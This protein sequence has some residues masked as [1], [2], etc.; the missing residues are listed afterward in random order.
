MIENTRTESTT[1]ETTRRGT[2]RLEDVINKVHIMSQNHHDKTIPVT[3]MEFS[4][5]DQM[6]IGSKK[7]EVLPSAQRLI[8]QRLRV[9]HSYLS[10]CDQELQAKNLNY[11]IEKE[12]QNRD[13][14]F[15]RFDGDKVRAV[16]TDS[17]IP[18]DNMQVLS[19]MLETGF[20]PEQ[21]VQYHL[22]ENLMVVKVPEYS[23]QFEVDTNDSIVPGVSIGN[24][25]VGVLAFSIQGYF[26]RLLCL[27][28]LITQTRGVANR[29]KHISNK[30]L[31]HFPEILDRVV[32]ESRQSQ[33][34][35]RF[36]L[37]SNVQDPMASISTFNK[38][39]NITNGT[40]DAV[41]RGFGRFQGHTMF[42]IINAYTAA[43]QEPG[44]TVEASHHL[45]S[46]GGK[47]LG[48]VKH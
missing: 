17:Y 28:G 46:V 48:M 37:Q 40:A 20:L 14:F 19:K 22:N 31:E 32:L 16:F 6:W 5:I 8:S 35:F 36:S 42:H 23:N 39:F 15:C 26:F 45:E 30:A 10:R 34:S 25:E 2:T 18:L 27:N 11:W 43:A 1:L 21:E 9:P 38:Q 41:E 29:F 33:D 13:T 24:S 7:M 12:A 4:S 44:L 3:D 47:I